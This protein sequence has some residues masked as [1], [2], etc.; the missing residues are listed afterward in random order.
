MHP[1]WKSGLEPNLQKY[2]DQGKPEISITICVSIIYSNIVYPQSVKVHMFRNTTACQQAA[3]STCN[4]QDQHA[5]C[6]KP[7]EGH[8][9]KHRSSIQWQKRTS[10]TH[11]VGGKGKLRTD[12][13]HTKNRLLDHPYKSALTEAQVNKNWRKVILNWVL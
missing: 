8:A 5:T 10:K 13:G 4:K 6:V 2:H 7:T 9:I 1:T 3:G 12:F 11:K